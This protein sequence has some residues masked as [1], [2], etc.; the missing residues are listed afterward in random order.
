MKT[1]VREFVSHRFDE[2]HS[3]TPYL[4]YPHWNTVSNGRAQPAA[5]LGYREAAAGPLF[6]EA[7]LSRPIEEVVSEALGRDIA[8]S[9][10]VEIGCLASLP[11]AALVKL[12]SQTATALASSHQI[13]VATLTRPLRSMFAR[14][15][16][17]VVELADA[18]RELVHD[19]D[20][21][22]SYYDMDPVVCAGDIAAGI[23]A[24]A[25]FT[26]RAVRS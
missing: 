16:L 15:A 20:A 1:D 22:G 6:L 11:S 12:W 2:A 5:A 8:R 13:V 18:K 24:L 17:P 14:L 7:Y 4:D 19:P 3:A 26:D 23:A 10:I 21:W 9:S 25:R